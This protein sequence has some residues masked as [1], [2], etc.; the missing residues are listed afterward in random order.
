MKKYI[1]PIVILA[2]VFLCLSILCYVELG[3]FNVI[4]TGIGMAR[5]RSGSAKVA[6]IADFP[7][8]AYLTTTDDGFSAF[9]AHL[10]EEGYSFAQE[11]NTIGR[12]TLERDGQ[13]ENIYW[14]TGGGFHKWI[15]GETLDEPPGEVFTMPLKPVIYLYPESVTDVTVKLDYIGELTCVYPAYTDGWRVTAHPDGTLVGENGMEYNYLYWE[16][17]QNSGYPMDRGFCVAG[18]DTAVFL[19]EALSKLGLTR[20]EANEFIVYWLPLMEDNPYNL[21]C[22]QGSAYTDAA[23]LE[24]SPAPDTVIRVFMTWQALDAPRQIEPQPLTA[25]VRSGFTV[26]EWGGSEIN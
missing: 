8:K 17:A 23:K 11:D 2:V 9:F 16:G 4:R 15:W 21:I 18:E 25:P 6:Q 3:S 20:R 26:V 24:I 7:H 22:F 12:V 14:S 13:Y 10:Q 1:K 5:I 19:E